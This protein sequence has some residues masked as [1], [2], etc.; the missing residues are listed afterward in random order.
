VLA[1]FEQHEQIFTFNDISKTYRRFQGSGLVIDFCQPRLRRQ[2]Y[3]LLFSPS[4]PKPSPSGYYCC[5]QLN[6]A[7]FAPRLDI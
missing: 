5:Q 4:S 7:I 2:K 3:V 6:I 1:K